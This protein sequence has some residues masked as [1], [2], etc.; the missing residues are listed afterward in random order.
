[1]YRA[2]NSLTLPAKLQIM[3]PRVFKRRTF[4]L[5]RGNFSAVNLKHAVKKRFYISLGKWA[6]FGQLEMT[7]IHRI[8]ILR[9]TKKYWNIYSQFLDQY[10]TRLDPCLKKS[11]FIHFIG[12]GPILQATTYSFLGP[13]LGFV[14]GMITGVAVNVFFGGQQA[15]T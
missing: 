11:Y 3:L 7:I 9:G 15:I 14:L 13:I 4:G 8:N 10:L 12:D 1:M 6:Y 5:T 2:I